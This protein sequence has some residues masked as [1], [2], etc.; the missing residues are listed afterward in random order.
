MVGYHRHVPLVVVLV[1]GYEEYRKEQAMHV[2]AFKQLPVLSIET[3]AK[4]GYVEDLL[5]DTALLRVAALRVRAA[6]QAFLLPWH[7]VQTVGPDAIMVPQDD[8]THTLSSESS[9]ASLPGIA[10]MRTLNVVDEV[11]AAT[12]SPSSPRHRHRMSVSHGI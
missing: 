3:G 6:G 4:L 9:L 12:A 7:T 2:D 5:F 1:N 11:G 10:T 8:A